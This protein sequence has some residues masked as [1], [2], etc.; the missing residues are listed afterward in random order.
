MPVSLAQEQIFSR[1]DTSEPSS[2]RNHL[3]FPDAAGNRHKKSLKRRAAE[4]KLAKRL[5]KK[6]KDNAKQKSNHTGD[7][8]ILID[9]SSSEEEGN[10]CSSDVYWTSMPVVMP[11]IRDWV[12]IMKSPLHLRPSSE[13]IYT[14][15]SRS[16]DVIVVERDDRIDWAL[17]TLLQSKHDDILAIDLEWRPDS[18]YSDNPVALIQIASD[19][20]CVLFRCHRWEVLPMQLQKLFASH[21]TFIAFSWDSCDEKKMQSTF[22]FGKRD[23]R[24]FMDLQN[25]AAR[26]GY[27]ESCGLSSLCTRVLGQPL[28]KMNHVSR[29]DWQRKTLNRIQITYAALDAFMTVYVFKKFRAWHASSMPCA[30]CGHLMGAELS[31]GS[32]SLMSAKDGIACMQ[33]DKMFKSCHSLICHMSSTGHQKT[34]HRQCI[35]CGRIS[36]RAISTV[37]E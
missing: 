10:A 21:M 29:S 16:L 25:V 28:P 33:C 19:S 26:L 9:D 35:S 11:Q 4:L 23:F 3:E 32:T 17:E 7:I 22:G 30:S 31:S 24:N 37:N 34:T 15:D 20:C 6:A 14:N 36:R 12:S 13:C 1:Q 8:K 27:P 5:E 2:S 18:K